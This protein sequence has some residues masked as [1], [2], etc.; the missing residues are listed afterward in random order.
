MRN[1]R[2]ERQDARK[3]Q[4]QE[5]RDKVLDRTTIEGGYTKIET[6]QLVPV[7]VSK[8]A[9]DI[10]MVV[11]PENKKIPKSNIPLIILAYAWGLV[12]LGLNAWFA[13]NQGSTTVDK[14]VFLSIGFVTEA[15]MFFLLSQAKNLYQHRQYGSFIGASLLYPFL[16]VFALTNSLGFAS[17]NLS[18]TSTARAERITPAVSDAQRKVEAISAYKT[19]ECKKL[20]DRCRQAVKDE[21]TALETLREARQAVSVLADPQIASAAKL[22]SWVSVGRYN[23]TAEDFANLRLFLLTLLPQLGGLVL[24]V[25][26][27]A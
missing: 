9:L 14:I 22:V 5:Y 27:R 16:F 7:S 11:V 25:A 20:G 23:P 6:K 8:P 26:K 17:L 21:Q 19:D 13:F 2:R 15:T 10:P 1:N 24:M 3:R 12:G 18:E 4:E